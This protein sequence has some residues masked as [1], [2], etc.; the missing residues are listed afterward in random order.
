MFE[1]FLNSRVY[2]YTIIK[3]WIYWSGCSDEL[4]LNATASFLILHQYFTFI[5]LGKALDY[6]LLAR[7]KIFKKIVQ[8]RLIHIFNQVSTITKFLKKSP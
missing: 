8:Y 1:L 2:D 5:L 6:R 4:F 3:P 7:Q